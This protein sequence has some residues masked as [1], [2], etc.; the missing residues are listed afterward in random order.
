MSETFTLFRDMGNIWSVA[1]RNGYADALVKSERVLSELA[2]EHRS[3]DIGSVGNTVA[4]ALDVAALRVG[5]LIDE[6][7]S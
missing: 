7:K 1:Y 6:G 4:A 5:L 3:D 2:A